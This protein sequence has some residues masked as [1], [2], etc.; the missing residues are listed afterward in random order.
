MNSKQAKRYLA[1]KGCHFE[2]GKRQ[3][4]DCQAWQQTISIA[5][6]W[7]KRNWHRALEGHFEAAWN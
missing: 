3:S 1:A 5:H 2:S 6:A 7:L 4:S